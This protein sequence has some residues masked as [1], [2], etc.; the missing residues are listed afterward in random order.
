MFREIILVVKIV[1]LV[2]K[3]QNKIVFQKYYINWTTLQVQ[4][5]LME[6]RNKWR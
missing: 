2:Y 1:I 6:F 4:I 5:T 3:I